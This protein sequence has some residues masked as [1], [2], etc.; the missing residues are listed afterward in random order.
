MNKKSKLI[1]S[2]L[3][4]FLILS[5]FSFIFLS[6]VSAENSLYEQGKILVFEGNYNKALKAFELAMKTG[7]LD[8][9]TALGV[10]YIGG[11]GV[12]QDNNKGFEYIKNAAD[13]SHPKAQYTLG[14]LYYLGAGVNQDFKKAFDWLSLSAEQNYVDAKYNL[15]VMYELG[16]GVSQDFEKAYEL[17]I[18]A[19]RSNNIESQ[20]KVAEMYQ[21]GKGVEKNLEKSEYWLKKNEESKARN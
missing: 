5:S 8:S 20:I 4:K 2:L 3:I 13:K 18:A 11:I 7:D 14:A 12:Q 1:N 17:Y 9:M 19:A 10:M 21:T 16:K 15:A 6:P